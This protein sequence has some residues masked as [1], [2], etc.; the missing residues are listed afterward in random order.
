MKVLVYWSLG[1][2]GGVQ[3]FEVLLIKALYELGL[4]AT[5]LMPSNVDLDRVGKYHGVDISN[6]KNLKVIMYKTV[7]CAN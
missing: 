4:D 6:L 7:N 3:R 5:A 2:I 1:G